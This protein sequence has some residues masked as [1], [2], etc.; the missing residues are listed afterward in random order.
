MYCMREE[1]KKKEKYSLKI[2]IML[3]DQLHPHSPFLTF[4]RIKQSHFF[5]NF[6][7]LFYTYSFFAFPFL[8]FKNIYLTW[9][10]E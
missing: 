7:S 4:S 5:P 10:K 3:T 8:K 6:I 9:G 2:L 1:L